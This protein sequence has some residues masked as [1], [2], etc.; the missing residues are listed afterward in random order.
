MRILFQLGRLE[1]CLGVIEEVRNAVAAIGLAQRRETVYREI[2]RRT[3]N[4]EDGTGRKTRYNFASIFIQ[5]NSRDPVFSSREV[6]YLWQR[7]LH[8]R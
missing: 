1:V 7:W 3:A 4:I 5:E 8:E 2:V 6:E